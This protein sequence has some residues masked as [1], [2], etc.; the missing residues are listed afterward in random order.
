MGDT[1]PAGPKILREEASHEFWQHSIRPSYEL[2]A[3]AP[4]PA[5]R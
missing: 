4:I 1:A 5:V 2:F 3:D